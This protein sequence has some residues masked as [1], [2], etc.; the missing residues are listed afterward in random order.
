MQKQSKCTDLQGN[1]GGMAWLLMDPPKQSWLLAT[2]VC[3]V[4]L[5]ALDSVSSSSMLAWN[6][7]NEAHM[8]HRLTAFGTKSL[9][10]T[11]LRRLEFFCLLLSSIFFS[12]YCPCISAGTWYYNLICEGKR[13][14][15]SYF[16]QRARRWKEPCWAPAAWSPQRCY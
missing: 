12:W 14:H 1:K 6:S 10:R 8:P 7:G 3:S 4:L 2:D 16:L 15:C 11:Q 5:L 9:P 13:N